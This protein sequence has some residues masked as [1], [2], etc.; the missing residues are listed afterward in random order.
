MVSQIKG[1]VYKNFGCRACGEGIGRCFGNG[2]FAVY[3]GIAFGEAVEGVTVLGSNGDGDVFLGAYALGCFVGHVNGI[4]VVA[5]GYVFADGNAFKVVIADGNDGIGRAAGG[6]LCRLSGRGGSRCSRGRA[7]G[8]GSI[9]G[10]GRGISDG[11]VVARNEC[12]AKQN[13]EKSR[14]Q[15]F[16]KHSEFL[17]LLCVR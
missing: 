7:L 6:V 9:G 12:E 11:G 4:R 8:G 1:A 5:E 17:S 13:R 15:S 16:R 2:R 14:N 3:D 10:A